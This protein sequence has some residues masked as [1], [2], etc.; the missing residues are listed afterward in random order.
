MCDSKTQNNNGGITATVICKTLGYNF[1]GIY[2]NNS[3]NPYG[4]STLNS[5]ISMNNII[6][7]LNGTNL[8]DDCSFTVGAT[9]DNINGIGVYCYESESIR[10]N[11]GI[12]N[13]DRGRL[14]VIDYQNTNQYG[15]VCDDVGTQTFGNNLAKVVCRQLGCLTVNTEYFCGKKSSAPCNVT[16]HSWESGSDI[17]FDDIRCVG[18]ENFITECPL[19]ASYKTTN[20]GTT[21]HIGM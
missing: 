10:L 5:A 12:D 3:V 17:I 11:N 8:K 21:E 19:L 4:S 1:G 9:C 13:W 18:N 6:C 15:T 2:F 20:C 14:E 7:P 16:A